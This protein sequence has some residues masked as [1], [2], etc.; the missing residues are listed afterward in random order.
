MTLGCDVILCAV[1]KQRGQVKEYYSMYTKREMLFL[2][3]FT[4]VPPKVMHPLSPIPL[5]V[6][7]VS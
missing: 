3:P 7:F 2:L 1:R 5:P 6:L 4:C